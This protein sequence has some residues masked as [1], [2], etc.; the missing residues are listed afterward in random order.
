MG[1]NLLG[2]TRKELRAASQP[3]SHSHADVPPVII[4]SIGLG[5]STKLV[6]AA[7]TAYRDQQASNP[8][9][10]FLPLPTQQDE[11]NAANERNFGNADVDADDYSS[12]NSPEPEEPP[13]TGSY[14]PIH[15][16][17]TL[18]SLRTQYSV[19]LEATA[20][21]WQELRRQL[22]RVYSQRKAWTANN[23]NGNT[24]L[25]FLH[26]DQS[27]H[28]T[29]R[30]TR[31]I[32]LVQSGRQD[33][34]EMSFCGCYPD[35]V[36]LLGFGYLANS[37]ETPSAAFDLT[38]MDDFMASWRV[39]P[40]S[41]TGWIQGKW[42]HHRHRLG[43]ARG[44]GT[45][46]EREP[47]PIFREAVRV[48]RDILSL[49]EK[50][51]SVVLKE[52]E[53]DVQAKRCPACFGP[54][55]DEP[56]NLKSAIICIDG[57]FQH[58]RA[59]HAAKYDFSH[60]RNPLFLPQHYVD[61]AKERV[62][63]TEAFKA[64]SDDVCSDSWVAKDDGNPESVYR[65][66]VDSGLMA[67]VCRHDHCLSMINLKRTGEKLYFAIAFVSYFL[68]VVDPTGSFL[69]MYDV[70]CNLWA[71]CR[72]RKIF[73]PEIDS[74]RLGMALAV[75]HAY[76]HIWLCQMLFNPRFLL[77]Y[78]LSD[79][80]GTERFWAFLAKLVSLNRNASSSLRLSNLQTRA[81]Y[82]NTMHT[83]NLVVWLKRKARTT[84]T[85]GNAAQVGLHLAQSH[86]WS[87]VSLREQWEAQ[88][89]DSGAGRNRDV[90]K[91]T[92]AKT[93]K[94]GSLLL[95]SDE[96]AK[97][98]N[99]LRSEVAAASNN[100]VNAVASLL[101]LGRRKLKLSEEIK[102]A[103]LGVATTAEAVHLVKI[104]EALQRLRNRVVDLKM[105]YQPLKN[106]QSGGRGESLLGNNGLQK[107]L[108][109]LG[110]PKGAVTTAVNIYD[111][112][113]NEYI[114]IYK[115][116]NPPRLAVS[117][118]EISKLQLGDPFFCDSTFEEAP[119]PWRSNQHCRD[120]IQW[121]LQADRVAEELPRVECEVRRIVAWAS[122]RSSLLNENIKR[123]QESRREWKDWKG[124]IVVDDEEEVR[125]PV[126]PVDLSSVLQLSPDETCE[127]VINSLVD[128]QRRH[129]LLEQ[130]WVSDGLAGLWDLQVGT[131][132][133]QQLIGILT[134]AY[135]SFGYDVSEVV[136]GE[137]VEREEQEE[138][139]YAGMEAEDIDR[140][141]ELAGVVIED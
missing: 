119:V 97:A 47:G 94:L 54:R 1:R 52:T 93:K 141:M 23:T 137:E 135:S 88:R 34:T 50:L 115:P 27:C 130:Q 67:C 124:R 87:K 65:G 18:P 77:G 112:A 53:R 62:A 66:K 125:P 30:R 39:T 83:F 46:Q 85:R 76:A 31:D 38:L 132:R 84:V 131:A 59:N 104:S 60:H 121:L 86:G 33:L 45:T 16:F 70:G 122:A 24:N 75:F 81:A 3:S 99:T 35:P 78:G 21:R 20:A 49:E 8:S 14:L 4:P 139:E 133:S 22:F 71:H 95:L 103:A 19:K 63:A 116:P 96:I 5:G 91:D 15:L 55:V 58:F 107:L 134:R 72:K 73:E 101:A 44:W 36:R 13:F 79:G 129:N 117:L 12:H 6:G 109:K 41:I 69:I 28:P 138:D 140:V 56:S 57:N 98:A 136:D 40:V 29:S 92:Q 100:V 89:V 80:E 105:I 114:R 68:N 42:E 48:Y 127:V 61:E 82:H 102:E 25:P 26:C 7:A 11:D 120:G 113:V 9:T 123:W 2:P 74:G 32:L 17:T 90:A 37:P 51:V 126:M 43:I 64:S 106:A 110:G 10:P 118:E 111:S 128:E 108:K